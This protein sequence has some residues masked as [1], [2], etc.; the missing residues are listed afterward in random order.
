[1]TFKFITHNYHYI[2]YCICNQSFRETPVKYIKRRQQEVDVDPSELQNNSGRLRYMT[3]TFSD[4][5]YPVRSTQI[6]IYPLATGTARLHCACQRGIVFFPVALP[7]RSGPCSLIQFRN[8]FSQTV[9]LLGRVISPS[10][11]LYLNTGQHKHRI[12][13]CT[14]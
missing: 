10:Q 9:G 11:G 5:V 6:S 8:Q 7:A 12:N 4:T 3:E 13:A 1:M 14:H 2:C